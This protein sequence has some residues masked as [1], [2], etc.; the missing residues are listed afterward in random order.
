MRILALF[1]PQEMPCDC[2]GGVSSGEVH[3]SCDARPLSGYWTLG[4]ATDNDFV[5]DGIKA[6]S[7][8]R[9]HAAL[10]YSE[11]AGR[12]E[13]IDLDSTCGTWVNG[14]RIPPRD[15]T[16]LEVRD[17]FSLATLPFN[18]VVLEG[19]NDTL[20]SRPEEPDDDF[21]TIASYDPVT[22]PPSQPQS[23]S[24][25]YGDSL[26]S[27]VQW[28]TGGQTVLEKVERFFVAVALVALLVVLI[29]VLV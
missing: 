27:L 28:L 21:E 26:Y 6:R 9:H 2:P 14:F 22:I 19:P 7:V 10:S 5:F 13:L 16:P 1:V 17:Q 11:L 25:S 4:R 3:L 18:F 12:W 8:S 29:T 23:S 24:R 15:P 20:E